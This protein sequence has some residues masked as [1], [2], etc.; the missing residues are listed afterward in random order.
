MLG[1]RAAGH[2]RLEVEGS[3]ANDFWRTFTKPHFRAT[4]ARSPALTGI[5]DQGG[6]VWRKCSTFFF[7]LFGNHLKDVDQFCLGFSRSAADGVASGNGRKIGNKRPIVVGSDHDN[8]S[9]KIVHPL[10]FYAPV[11]D[12]Q[13]DRGGVWSENAPREL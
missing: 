13:Q 5:C 2:S 12:R 7:V 6:Y 1:E 3:D 4:R 11:V 8:V 10:L 9:V